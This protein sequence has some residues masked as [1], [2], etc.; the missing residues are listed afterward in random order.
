MAVNCLLFGRSGPTPTLAAP[1]PSDPGGGTV[2]ILD[3]DAKWVS[4]PKGGMMSMLNLGMD[5]CMLIS[6]LFFKIKTHPHTLT[7]AQV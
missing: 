4:E 3:L 1:G 2:V 5:V 7:G 6:T